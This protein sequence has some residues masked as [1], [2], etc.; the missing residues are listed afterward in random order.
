VLVESRAFPPGY[1][2]RL[3]SGQ[4]REAPVPPLFVFVAVFVIVLAAV[5]FVLSYAGLVRL[6]LHLVEFLPGGSHR[7]LLFF[8]VA[9]V[10]LV[11]LIPIYVA[12][13]DTRIGIGCRGPQTHFAL[14]EVEL[15]V[16]RI[17]FFLLV[18]DLLL[19][20]IGYLLLFVCCFLPVG[21][22]R[23][24][25]DGGRFRSVCID[26]QQKQSSN[27]HAFRALHVIILSQARDSDRRLPCLNIKNASDQEP[28]L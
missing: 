13:G 17:N 25:I 4:A 7:L 5:L 1:T 22:G 18:V 21:G 6:L 14:I 16:Q 26:R 2:L 11:V 10:T 23:S 8:E 20:L 19:P 24:G 3:R 27:G 12:H 28:V 9:L 15:M